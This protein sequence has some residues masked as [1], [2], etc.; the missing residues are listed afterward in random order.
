MIS[1]ANRGIG[2]AVAQTLGEQ[3]FEL[4]L[5]ARQPATISTDG[6]PGNCLTHTW[7]AARPQDSADWVA[8]TLA[9]FGRID[10]MV[11][12]AGVM[13]PAGLSDG[14]PD[15][16]DLMWAVNFKGP[17][18]LVQAAL[19]S[20]RESGHGRVANIVSLAGKRL[21]APGNLGYGASKFAALAL[22]HAIRQE[23]WADGIRATAVCPG[24][25]DTEMVSGVQPA[26]G[27]FKIPPD[28][29]AATVAYA[30]AL[31]NEASVAE[32]L[33]NSRLEL[34]M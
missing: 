24:L 21:L 9:Q 25:V 18:H 30:L 16:M 17:L 8:A 28:T 32:L 6:L 4:S 5:G 31:P 27:Q 20:L 12:N 3:G 1:G 14:S 19:P 15:D 11:L 7:D 10:A 23:G 2:A 29:I 26:A 33:V 13:V 22:T 34:A